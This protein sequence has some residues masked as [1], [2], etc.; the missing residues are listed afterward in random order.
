MRN[1]VVNNAYLNTKILQ[2]LFQYVIN[3]NLL[4]GSIWTDQDFVPDDVQI[5]ETDRKE[6]H[7][8]SIFD[9]ILYN[10]F[11]NMHWQ[12]LPLRLLE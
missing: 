12:M 11:A 1:L 9:N 10:L 3:N 6:M 7:Q 8:L 2:N 4:Q 5:P